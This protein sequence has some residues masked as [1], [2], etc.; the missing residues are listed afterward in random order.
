MFNL[1][2][3]CDGPAPRAA[4]PAGRRPRRL[5]AQATAM[6]RL[7]AGEAGNNSAHSTEKTN[8]QK[9]GGNRDSATD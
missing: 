4:R 9:A 6:P 8:Y 3:F 1:R 7:V 2:T 5:G